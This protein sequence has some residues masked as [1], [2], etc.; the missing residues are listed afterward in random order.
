MSLGIRQNVSR[1]IKALM[2]STM[3]IPA[4][5]M[6]SEKP[7]SMKQLPTPKPNQRNKKKQTIETTEQSGKE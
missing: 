4:D 2:I 5:V 7:E 6:L 1:A 3:R